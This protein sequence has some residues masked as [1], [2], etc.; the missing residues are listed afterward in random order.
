[1]KKNRIECEFGSLGP[2]AV[3]NE[4]GDVQVVCGRGQSPHL[5][6]ACVLKIVLYLLWYHPEVIGVVKERICGHGTKHNFRSGRA[7]F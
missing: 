1:M 3:L 5:F 4:I 7:K 6:F 2:Q